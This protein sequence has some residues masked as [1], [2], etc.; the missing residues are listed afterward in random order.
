M[1]DFLGTVFSKR[2]LMRTFF[3]FLLVF[4]MLIPTR[5]VQAD[6]WGAAIAATLL[7]QVLTTIKSQIEGAILGTLKVAAITMLNSRVGQMIGGSSAG[8]AMVVSDWNQFLYQGPAEKVNL[9]MNDFFS[10]TTRG[11]YASANYV[12]VGDTQSDVNGSYV[13]YLVG[14]A[15]Q[16]IGFGNIDLQYNLDD[17]SPSPELMF[18]N[19]DWRGFNAFISNPMNN[20]WGFRNITQKVYGQKLEQERTQAKIEVTSPGFIAPK[21]D[22]KTVAPVATIEGMVRD[23]QNIGNQLV[24]A[25]K[26]PGEFLSGVVGALINK[27]ITNLVQ[28]GVGKI[29][30]NIKREIGNF[31]KKVAAKLNK[32]D[33]QLGPAAKYLKT[34]SQRVDTSVKPYTSP[35]PAAGSYCGDGSG[36]C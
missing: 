34:A 22:G 9:F 20:P 3:M 12:G 7:D 15:Q 24:A 19:G 28:R 21:V 14:S 10:T 8:S 32:L 35:P 27:T 16:S 5:F 30:A 2:F 36:V 11:K 4:N 13:S 6:V 25:A 29:Q 31:D 17:F 18:Q 33:K 23:T 26:N 1:R